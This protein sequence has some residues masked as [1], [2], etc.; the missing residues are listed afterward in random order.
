MNAVPVPRSASKVGRSGTKIWQR[1][2]GPGSGLFEP[3]DGTGERLMMRP[4]VDEP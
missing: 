2:N 1:H 4:D 3:G